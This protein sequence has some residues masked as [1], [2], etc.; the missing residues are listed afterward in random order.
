MSSK[1]TSLTFSVSA[2]YHR[3]LRLNL[4]SKN[5]LEERSTT[6]L[7]RPKQD[8]SFRQNQVIHLISFWQQQAVLRKTF[9]HTHPPHTRCTPHPQKTCNRLLYC[10]LKIARLLYCILK[11][12][13]QKAGPEKSAKRWQ[14]GG[15]KVYSWTSLAAVLK[16]VLFSLMTDKIIL[17]MNVNGQTLQQ[18]N[19]V[20]PCYSEI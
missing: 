19:T 15:K 10:I 7:Q 6:F 2:Y 5:F 4:K 3:S 9:I 8:H 20:I 16:P 12:V 11:K 17:S 18:S 13:C 1:E 14:V